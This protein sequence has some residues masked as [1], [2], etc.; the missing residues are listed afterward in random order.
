VAALAL[1]LVSILVPVKLWRKR[2]R[3]A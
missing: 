2:R 1:F 3:E